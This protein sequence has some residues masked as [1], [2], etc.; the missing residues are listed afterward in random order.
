MGAGSATVE[1]APAV[2]P[3]RVLKPPAAPL[4]SIPTSLA[5]LNLQLGE[6]TKVQTLLAEL[7]DAIDEMREGGPLRV[8]LN[9][10]P[11]VRPPKQP[12]VAGVAI[13]RDERLW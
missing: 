4:P 2:G 10:R 8:Q 6:S 1:A 13:Q 12:K 5:R 9:V 11:D 7:A 3:A